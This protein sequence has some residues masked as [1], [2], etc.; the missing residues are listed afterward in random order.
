MNLL[1]GTVN[2][3]YLG[4]SVKQSGCCV[5]IIEALEET[6]FANKCSEGQIHLLF[7]TQYHVW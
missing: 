6:L 4:A 5:T 2:N 7:F 3:A 1:L